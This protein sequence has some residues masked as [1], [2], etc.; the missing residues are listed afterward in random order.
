MYYINDLL[1][2]LLSPNVQDTSGYNESHVKTTKPTEK[3]TK[4]PPMCHQGIIWSS[5]VEQNTTES[6]DMYEQL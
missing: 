4:D 2:Y 6:T 5:N 3:K 1:T